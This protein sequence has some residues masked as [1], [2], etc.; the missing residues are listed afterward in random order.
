MMFL[1]AT[2]LQY[3]LLNNYEIGPHKLVFIDSPIGFIVNRE[4][5]NKPEFAGIRD[6]LLELEQVDYSPSE[7]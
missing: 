3:A 7:E 4:I 1:K 6:K 5:L 2:N